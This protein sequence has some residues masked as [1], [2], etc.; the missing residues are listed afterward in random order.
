M[1]EFTVLASRDG[2]PI[3]PRRLK[4][5]ARAFTDAYGEASTSVLGDGAAVSCLIVNEPELD[6]RRFES[7]R[8]WMA[9]KGV[10]FDGGEEGVPLSLARIFEGLLH[11]RREW[12]GRLEGGFALVAW[13][14]EQGELFALNDPASTLNLYLGAAGRDCLATTAVLAPARALG[15]DPAPA[16]VREFLARGAL[17]APNSFFS[18]I[19]RLNVGQSATLAGDGWR[20]ET[21]WEPFAD[22][23]VHANRDEAAAAYASALVRA[24]ARIDAAAGGLA[25]DLTGGYDTRMVVAAALRAGVDFTVT[26][27]RAPDEIAMAS[28]IARAMGFDHAAYGPDLFERLALT[29]DVV[30][31]LI[32]R[33]AGERDFADIAHASLSLRMLR[34]RRRT[35]L[36]GC[37]GELTRAR[38]WS[39]EL[40]NVGR[41]GPPN[42]GRLLR[43]RILGQ[44][45]PPAGLYR[46]DWWPRCAAEMEHRVRHAFRAPAGA[47][48]AQRLEALGVWRQTSNPSISLS[49]THGWMP[50]VHPLSTRAV[51]E[52]ALAIP[53][54]WKLGARVTRAVI[55]RLSPELAALPTEYGG[56]AAPFR[57]STL[58]RETRHALK[59]SA[60]ALSRLDRCFAGGRLTR[61]LPSRPH[62][63]PR[64]ALP[65][66][67]LAVLDPERMFSRE[68]FNPHGLAALL[69]Y[70]TD[71]PARQRHVARILNVE[72]LFRECDFR[73]DAAFL[74]ATP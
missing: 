61:P 64:P 41:I 55:Q 34:R 3:P 62:A 13:F 26:T 53:W 48:R 49:S 5:L 46:R 36:Q 72:L 22:T 42:V 19:E 12:I 57:A 25:I 43:F 73:P 71:D 31:E 68:L 30:R 35:R 40:W 58:H 45:P 15:I 54:R 65:D 10:A 16:G 51:M 4:A 50:S 28:R 17:L 32:H 39:Y 24:V 66:D 9:L 23:S 37:M 6:I 69:A 27:G 70:G 1:S 52:A 44:G 29:P 18:G 74:D 21:H 67:L 20:R 8:G 14:A 2:A 59:Y 60:H 47:T 7:E 11:E 63:G 33:T 38:H 56:T